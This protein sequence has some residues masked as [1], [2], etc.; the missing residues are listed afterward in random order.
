MNIILWAG[1]NLLIRTICLG[2][3][4]VK[5]RS[6][7]NIVWIQAIVIATTINHVAFTFISEEP[8]QDLDKPTHRHTGTDLQ[9]LNKN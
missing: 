3:A 1:K 6:I 7:V 8:I 2:Q 5:N 4:S 9:G